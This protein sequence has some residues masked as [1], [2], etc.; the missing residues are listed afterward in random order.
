VYPRQDSYFADVHDPGSLRHR[1]LEWHA[2]LA[3]NLEDFAPTSDDERRDR[4]FM[5]SSL[6][7]IRVVIEGAIEIESR[8]WQA[9]HRPA[10]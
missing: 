9:I 6:A 4:S 8:R 2:K 5:E 7:N 1:L 3:S 10:E